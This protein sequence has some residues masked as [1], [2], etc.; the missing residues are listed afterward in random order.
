M[1]LTLCKTNMAA[2]A[3]PDSTR[4]FQRD[5]EEEESQFGSTLC[6][7]SSYYSVFVVRLAI[8]VSIRTNSLIHT[9]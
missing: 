9:T 2:A 4:T 3:S 5:V 1:F 8:M 7:S 6:L